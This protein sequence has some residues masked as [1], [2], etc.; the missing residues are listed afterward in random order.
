MAFT[1]SMFESIKGALEKTQKKSEGGSK[2]FLKLEKG[3]T[4]VVRLLPNKANPEKTW[5]RYWTFGWKSFS[6]GNYV[7]AV[8]PTS[9]ELRDPIAEER[10]KIYRTGSDVEKEKIKAVR[11]SEKILIDVYVV[12][13][14]VNPE[15][16]GT[17]K[18]LRFGKQLFSIISNAIS[19]ED[20]DEFGLKVFDLSKNGVNFKIKVDEQGDFANYT[21]S[22]FTGSVDLG[23]NEQQIETIY[24]Q[25]HDLEN[26]FTPRSYEEL[27]EMFY[28]HYYCVSGET[29][30]APKT[31]AVASKSSME[32]DEEARIKRILSEC[33]D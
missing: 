33:D 10:I 12:N 32:E 6:T 31:E 27:K 22:R 25:V 7:Q 1:S 18:I 17:V 24:S 26:I 2:D 11:R 8:S 19:G 4:Y 14:P 28:T 3:K 30:A 9:W 5:F 13:D 16:N 23:L 20:A 29:S 21:A 15:N